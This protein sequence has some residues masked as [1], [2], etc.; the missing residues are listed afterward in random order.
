MRSVEGI[1]ILIGHADGSDRPVCETEKEPPAEAGAP[2]GG[3]GPLLVSLLRCAVG[4][5]ELVD[6]GMGSVRDFGQQQ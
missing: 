2:T 5:P 1:A 6:F 4:R 3:I